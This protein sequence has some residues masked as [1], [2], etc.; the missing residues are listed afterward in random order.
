MRTARFF[1]SALFAVSFLLTSSAQSVRRV[2]QTQLPMSEDQSVNIPYF[3]QSNGMKSILALNNN[4]PHATVVDLTIYNDSGKSLRIAPVTLPP[5]SITEF[6]LE[7]LTKDRE[8]EFAS[9]NVQFHYHGGPM[10]VTSQLGVFDLEHRISFDSAVVSAMDFMS[11]QLNGIVWRPDH[12]TRAF[13]ALTNTTSNALEVKANIGERAETVHLGSHE[14]HVLGLQDDQEGEDAR[15]QP[16]AVLLRLH[17]DGAPGA[18]V[19]TGYSFN[20][21]TGFSTNFTLFDPAIAVSSKLAGAHIRFGLPEGTEGFP[22]GTRF[23]AP[24]QLANVGATTLTAHVAAQIRFDGGSYNPDRILLEP[25]QTVAIDI[26][27]IKASREKDIRGN[28]FPE[29]AVR[30]QVIWW[31][32]LPGSM[33]GR[34]ERTNTSSGIARSFSCGGTGCCPPNFYRAWMSPAS[35]FTGPVGDSGTPLHTVRGN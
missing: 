35:S 34:A 26:Q 10:A 7:D 16:S 23:R 24:L 3:E 6:K 15:S 2:A 21:R 13:V 18:L 19:A 12:R 5:Q 29:A 22:A 9:G 32:E 20:R 1:L 31:E 4:L 11:S 25:F 17:D 14:T 28:V 33:I 27:K 8:S 30:G